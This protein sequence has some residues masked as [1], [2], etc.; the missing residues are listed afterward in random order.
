MW[1]QKAVQEVEHA[2]DHESAAERQERFSI[3][4]ALIQIIA[5]RDKTLG[6][7]LASLFESDMEQATNK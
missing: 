2:S 7:R 3:A 6:T 4:R 1:W 5:P